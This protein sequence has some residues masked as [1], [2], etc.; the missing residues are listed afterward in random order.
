MVHRDLR[1]ANIMIDSLNTVRIIDLGSVSVAGLSERGDRSEGVVGTAQYT[2]P[3]CYMGMP[4]TAQSDIF[5]LG[6]IVYQ[7]LC[8]ALPYGNSV[9][10]AGSARELNRLGYR[11]LGDQGR[12]APAWLD[13]ALQKALSIDPRKRYAEAFEFAAEIDRPSTEYLQQTKRPLL[14][15][16][17][18]LFWKCVAAALLTVVV[19]QCGRMI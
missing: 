14:E 7:M 2:A 12:E 16:N 11:S 4:D 6:V 18:T 1:P 10:K 15:R 13:F 9:A 5:S 19:A 3:E 17:P 8:G